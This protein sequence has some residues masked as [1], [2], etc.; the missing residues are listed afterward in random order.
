MKKHIL[1][2]A[3]VFMLSPMVNLAGST[4]VYSGDSLLRMANSYSLSNYDS[5]IYF[6]NQLL[7]MEGIS[8]KQK[9]E[10]LSDLS[11]MLDNKG[12]VDT[13]IVL[14]YQAIEIGLKYSLDTLLAKSYLRLGNYY[15]ELGDN[16]NAKEFYYKTIEKNLSVTTNGAWGAL[17]ILYSNINKPDSARMFLEKSLQYFKS[18]D[19]TQQKVLYNISSLSGQIGIICF[20]TGK[21]LEGMRYFKESLRISRKIEDSK[22]TILNLLN[23]SIAYDIIREPDKAEEVLSEALSMTDSLGYDRLRSRTYLLFSDHFSEIGDY[24]QAY[25]YLLIHHDLND[26]LDKA[27]YKNSMHKKEVEFLKEL[28]KK[29]MEQVQLE[30][31]KERLFLLLTF[32]GAGLVFIL[33]SVFLYRKIKKG[34]EERKKLEEQSSRLS[35]NL[36]DARKKLSKL[37]EHLKEQ[38]TLIARLQK[39]LEEK[40]DESEERKSDL[41]GELENRKILRNDDWQQYMEVFELLYPDFMNRILAEYPELSEGDKRQLIMLKLKYDRKKSAEILGI[42]PDSI[43]RARQRLSKKLGLKDVTELGEFVERV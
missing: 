6:Y 9:M 35:S 43:K 8:P 34:N 10:C 33:I 42:S 28:Q 39:E 2:F 14:V 7:D 21:E 24:R 40:Q 13:A 29:E 5:A 12:N 27:A 41:E 23:L 30:K 20:D 36:D 16:E 26:S 38:N 37:N 1:F 31:E 3:L 4:H 22:N 15:K 11:M 19:T 18:K 32:G 17:G 25:E